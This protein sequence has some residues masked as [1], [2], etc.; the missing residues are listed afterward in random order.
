MLKRLEKQNDGIFKLF[1]F[2]SENGELTCQIVEPDEQAIIS[3][4]QSAGYI[5]EGDRVVFNPILPDV[6]SAPFKI[7]IDITDSC[8]LNCKHC[9]TK[10]LNCGSELPLERLKEIADECERLGVFY[11]KL[12]GG[13]PLLHKNFFDVVRYFRQ[14]GIYLSL[15]TNGYLVDDDMAEFLAQYNVKTTVSVEGT[16]KIDAFIRG[17]GHYDVAMNALDTLVWHNANVAMRVTLTRYLLDTDTIAELIQ[18]AE[19]HNVPLK[20]SYCRPAGSSLD[21]DCLITKNDHEKYL[22]VIKFIN[23]QSRIHKISMDEGMMYNLPESTCKILYKGRMCGAANRSMHI[24]TSGE[25]SP[26]VFMG[27]S[28]KEAGSCY[29][30]GDINAYWSEQKGEKFRQVR[31]VSMPVKCQGCSRKCKYECLS[32][33]L[34]FSGSFTGDDP[35]C[36]ALK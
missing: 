27:A 29:A 11:V 33:R 28:Y 24:N 6:Y 7:Y 12:G 1:S 8:Q 30:K 32:T 3:S 22:E 10:H 18:T 36:L 9:L 21:N 14:K 20:I 35:N 2:N 5:G 25:I 17:E 16:E 34:Y 15:S 26:C 19:A 4:L 31:S 23:E 13:E